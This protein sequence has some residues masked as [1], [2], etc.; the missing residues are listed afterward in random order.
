MTLT[1][2]WLK[3]GNSKLQPGIKLALRVYEQTLGSKTAL[4]EHAAQKHSTRHGA[5]LT[6]IHTINIGKHYMHTCT[7]VHTYTAISL[8][9]VHN[10]YISTCTYIYASIQTHTYNTFIQYNL[11]AHTQICT[12]QAH[13]HVTLFLVF[14]FLFFR[15]IFALLVLD[16]GNLWILVKQDGTQRYLY[17]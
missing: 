4:W 8:W 3:I 6:Y 9:K 5:T 10:T 7:Y 1:T 12:Q 16:T 15:P 2:E 17:L 11:Y 14:I 13:T